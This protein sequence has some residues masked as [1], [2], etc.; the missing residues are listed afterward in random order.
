[1]VRPGCYYVFTLF[2]A[3]RR[4]VDF[5]VWIL[6]NV[7]PHIFPFF[8]KAVVFCHSLGFLCIL[9]RLIML[10]CDD[11]YLSFFCESIYFGDVFNLRLLIDS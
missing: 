10:A 9:L 1:M 2:T 7:Y 8:Y 3:C 11:G 5:I 4:S 6:L